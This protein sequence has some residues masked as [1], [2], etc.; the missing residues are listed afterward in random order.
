LC[1]RSGADHDRQAIIHSGYK[2]FKKKMRFDF[3]NS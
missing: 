3:E 1:N 2:I